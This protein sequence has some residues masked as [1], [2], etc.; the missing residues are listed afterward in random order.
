MSG[1]ERDVKKVIIQLLF[2]HEHKRILAI[3]HHLPISQ[4]DAPGATL[5]LANGVGMAA[6]GKQAR[7]ISAVMS[8]YGLAQRIGCHYTQN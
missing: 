7:N 2:C 3:I 8:T 5:E 4:V 6:Q 1:L